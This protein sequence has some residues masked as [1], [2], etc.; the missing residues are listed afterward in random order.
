MQMGVTVFRTQRRDAANGV[1]VVGLAGGNFTGGNLSDPAG[2]RR[3][4]ARSHSRGFTAYWR[5]G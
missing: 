2:A 3:S 1:N 5:K 4:K